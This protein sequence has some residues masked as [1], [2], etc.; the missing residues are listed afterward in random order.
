MTLAFV[1]SWKQNWKIYIKLMIIEIWNEHSAKIGRCPLLQLIE[2]ATKTLWTLKF[3]R[4]THVQL[5]IG[6]IRL[7]GHLHTSWIVNGSS[8]LLH[9]IIQT[10]LMFSTLSVSNT[11]GQNFN[12]VFFCISFWSKEVLLNLVLIHIC[13]R[14]HWSQSGKWLLPIS[15]NC[16]YQLKT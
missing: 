11:A 12:L 5:V 16:F 15:L 6:F 2:V 13:L 7:G 8:I 9:I 3:K 10:N 4:V 14:T 1:T